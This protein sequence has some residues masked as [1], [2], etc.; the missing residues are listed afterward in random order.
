MPVKKLVRLIREIQENAGIE[1]GCQLFTGNA[2][3]VNEIVFLLIYKK[4]R[5]CQ[6]LF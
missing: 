2:I 1:P 3:F 6:G 4:F 5:F